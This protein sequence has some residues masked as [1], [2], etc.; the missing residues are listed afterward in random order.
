M[1]PVTAMVDGSEELDDANDWCSRG[2]DQDLWSELTV[3]NPD[4]GPGAERRPTCGKRLLETDDGLGTGQSLHRAMRA[5]EAVL[6][7][8][9]DQANP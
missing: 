2:A 7:L 3:G 9:D 4:G 6:G 1:C 8:R 5:R